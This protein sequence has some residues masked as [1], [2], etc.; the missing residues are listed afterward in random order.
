MG[1]SVSL[2]NIETVFAQAKDE[3]TDTQMIQVYF[4]LR[5]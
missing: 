1:C 2:E 5:R 3:Q 4:E